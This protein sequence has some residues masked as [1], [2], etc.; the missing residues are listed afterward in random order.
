VYEGDD[1]FGVFPTF[2]VSPAMRAN[3]I[4]GVPGIE[5]DLSHVGRL[6]STCSSC[7]YCTAS[8]MSRCSSR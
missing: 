3:M 2:I 1:D 5:L 6:P 8:T 4:S 7:R